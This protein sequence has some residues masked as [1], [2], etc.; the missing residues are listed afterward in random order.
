MLS[1]KVKLRVQQLLIA[2]PMPFERLVERLE[3]DYFYS[4][5]EQIRDGAYIADF[6]NKDALYKYWQ[7]LQNGFT[8]LGFYR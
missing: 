6:Y 4:D 7:Y 5:S 1:N 2:E 3:S 8:K